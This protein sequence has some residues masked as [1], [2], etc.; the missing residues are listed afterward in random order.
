LNTVGRLIVLSAAIFAS[1][2]LVGGCASNAARDWAQVSPV[3][4]P[5]DS[6]QPVISLGAFERGS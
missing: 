3:I 2:T 6:G 5:S 4:A 1:L